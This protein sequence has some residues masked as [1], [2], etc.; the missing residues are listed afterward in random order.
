MDGNESHSVFDV[1]RCFDLGQHCEEQIAVGLHAIKVTRGLGGIRISQGVDF[2]LID[3]VVSENAGRGIDS[4]S[5]RIV[6]VTG[7]TISSNQC[8]AMPGTGCFCTG[9]GVFR[10]SSTLVLTD[11]TVSDNTAEQGGGIY[12][13]DAYAGG[14]LRLANSTVSGNVSRTWGGG[15]VVGAGTIINSTVSGNTAMELGPLGGGGI[16]HGEGGG[17]LTI[18]NSTVSD[19]IADQRGS[20]ITTFGGT[21]IWGNTLIDGDCSLDPPEE[22]P[23]ERV[24]LG[25]NIE[26][27]GNTCG[28]DPDGSD[29]VS[30][31]A[32]DLK[33]GELADNGGP[34]MT[35]ALGEGSVAIDVIPADDCEVETD[36]RGEPR[37]SMCDV[38]AFEVQP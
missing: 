10:G 29:Q 6:T 33:L 9:G 4:D 23:G 36:Q 25:H 11:T 19:N 16:L 24:S 5:E 22:R 26:S 1:G 30:V 31:S 2:D 8:C 37:D 14:V 18:I 32:D 13:G 3:S 15:M 34:T 21:L 28:F 20:A 17:P 38:G 7:C 35:H 12:S 27:P